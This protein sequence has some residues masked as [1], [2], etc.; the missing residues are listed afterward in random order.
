MATETR[1]R[2]VDHIDYVTPKQVERAERVGG[3]LKESEFEEVEVVTLD[4]PDGEPFRITKDQVSSYK[5]VAEEMVAALEKEEED[6][7]E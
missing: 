4:G 6:E 2:Y 3:K 1:K 7:D 5:K